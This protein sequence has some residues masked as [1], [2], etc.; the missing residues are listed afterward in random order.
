MTSSQKFGMITH[1]L[2]KCGMITHEL[3][4]TLVTCAF[5][6]AL[7]NKTDT[8]CLPHKQEG[9]ETKNCKRNAV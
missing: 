8:S 1:E 2:E 6:C 5:Q 7:S 9:E 4:L 3:L